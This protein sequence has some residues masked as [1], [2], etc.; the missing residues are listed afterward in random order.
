MGKD[1]FEGSSQAQEIFRKADDVLGFSLGNLC[2]EGPEES[3]RLTYHTQPAIMT[4]SYAL[5][6]EFSDQGIKPDVVAGHSI[7]EYTALAVAGVLDFPT[8]VELVYSRGKYM[9]EACPA[10][11]GSMAALIGLDEEGAK[12]ML[13]QLELPDGESL[14][15]AGINCPGQV[16]IAGHVS[17]LKAAIGQ[18]RDFGGRMGVELNV[19]GPFHSRLMKPAEQGLGTRLE[20]IEF[21]N[22]KVPVVPNVTAKAQ[23]QGSELKKCLMSQLTSPVL[24]EASVR[25]ILEMGVES[26]VEFG[27][28]NV[29]AGM[30]KKID[31]KIPVYPVYDRV[32]LEK[33]VQETSA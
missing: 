7:G 9:D 11:T 4:T 24:W 22:A 17:S 21:H 19:S 18:V 29:L 25:Q 23:M 10:G 14:D 16:V 13:S 6:R 26:F 3:L 12:K 2:F 15:I 33:A 31:R 28:G 5:A 1:L 8:A 32:S 27:A 30:I 20:E